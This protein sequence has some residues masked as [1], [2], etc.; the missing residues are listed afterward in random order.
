MR[1]SGQISTFRAGI[2][3]PHNLH[4]PQVNPQ[5]LDPAHTP[6]QAHR[7]PAE[8]IPGRPDSDWNAIRPCPGPVP[9]NQPALQ[10]TG[11]GASSGL[12]DRGSR[13]AN[14]QYVQG[15]EVSGGPIAK[16]ETRVCEAAAAGNIP[17]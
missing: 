14:R 17:S 16:L 2:G 10:T 15:I 6:G 9:I 12:L 7:V 4:G 11:Q 1:V 3:T 5:S 13:Q 8:M